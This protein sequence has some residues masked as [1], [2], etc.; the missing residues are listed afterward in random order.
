MN[1]LLREAYGCRKQCVRPEVSYVSDC[2]NEVV[3]RRVSRVTISCR[4]TS[5]HETNSELIEKY[6]KSQV[7]SRIQCLE[8]ARTALLSMMLCVVH[9]F[10]LVY[11]HVHTVDWRHFCPI[12][13][14]VTML[15]HFVYSKEHPEGF[16][17]AS[18]TARSIALAASR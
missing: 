11:N 1:G 16:Q 4:F 15:K 10:A 18:A 2:S 8:L 6:A 12:F 3:C 5:H 14:G 7:N 13:F 17:C 9:W